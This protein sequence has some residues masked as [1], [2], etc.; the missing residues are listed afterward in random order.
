MKNYDDTIKTVFDRIHQHAVVKKRKKKIVIKTILPLC[1]FFLIAFLG[2]GLWQIQWHQAD[3]PV[4]S[5][6]VTKPA[7]THH[8]T[9]TP[10][11]VQS[12]PL[13]PQPP[14]EQISQVPPP[15]EQDPTP[16]EPSEDQEEPPANTNP[17]DIHGDIAQ[18]YPKFVS[19]EAL[20]FWVEQGSGAYEAERTEYWKQAGTNDGLTYYQ[21]TKELERVASLEEI[22]FHAPSRSYH[23]TYS[24]DDGKTLG[25][26]IATAR[27]EG[28]YAG[29]DS[30]Y[31]TRKQGYLDGKENFGHYH[32][33]AGGID[34]YWSY[35]TLYTLVA[36]MQYGLCHTASLTGHDTDIL[37]ELL[38]YLVLE[39]VTVTRTTDS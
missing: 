19:T 5:S 30:F 12:A 2:I 14:S 31:E 15:Q 23:Y 3:Q 20:R 16:Q 8:N 33:P 1:C 18:F 39:Q 11:N 36:W 9:P 13:E 21:P 4:P 34:F 29:T 37:P 35:G 32:D 10:S 27:V 26:N 38:P 7:S 22:E 24:F 6:E 25:V 28:F 17:S